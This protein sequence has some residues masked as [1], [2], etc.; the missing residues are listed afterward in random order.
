MTNATH[1][2]SKISHEFRFGCVGCAY[3]L[4]K[5]FK[6]AFRRCL[7]YRLFEDFLQ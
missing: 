1:D 5:R 3:P 4:H 2:S 7:I 6:V